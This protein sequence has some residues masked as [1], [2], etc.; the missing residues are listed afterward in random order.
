MSNGAVNL[1]GTKPLNSKP[2]IFDGD[3]LNDAKDMA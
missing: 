3:G 1:C 2:R